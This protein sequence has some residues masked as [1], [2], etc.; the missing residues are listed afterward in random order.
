MELWYHGHLQATPPPLPPPGLRDVH[1]ALVSTIMAGFMIVVLLLTLLVYRELHHRQEKASIRQKRDKARAA[2]KQDED[3]VIGLEQKARVLEQEKTLGHKILALKE[4][5]EG[6][7]QEKKA[8]EHGLDK[9]T[10]KNSFLSL[11]NASLEDK[12][13]TTSRNNA[14]LTEANTRLEQKNATLEQ[15]YHSAEQTNSS[16]MAQVMQLSSE[17]EVVKAQ[18][19]EEKDGHKSTRGKLRNA[20][21][22]LGCT[23]KKIKQLYNYLVYMRSPEAQQQDTAPTDEAPTEQLT[24]T[25]RYPIEEDMSPI[26]S[27]PLPTFGKATTDDTAQTEAE[28]AETPPETLQ[29]E[30][31]KE[32]VCDSAPTAPKGNAAFE[33][34]I[35]AMSSPS[36][37]KEKESDSDS[38]DTSGSDADWTDCEPSDSDDAAMTMTTMTTPLHPR[39][40]QAFRA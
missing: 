17:V 37:E 5:N 22:G 32:S 28:R 40:C 3:D 31:E 2:R 34:M 18:L 9:S 26:Q 14:H 19:V 7:E 39:T 38:A 8:L 13:L 21:F 24:I 29:G 23:E 10:Q 12:V 1:V 33:D 6:L 30:P 16:L 4:D 36:K 11:N 20:Q 27:D 25:W 15:D 35:T